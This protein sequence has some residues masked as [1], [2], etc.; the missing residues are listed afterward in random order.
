MITK[1]CRRARELFSPYFDEALS[2]DDNS[3]LE[4]HLSVCASCEKAYDRYRT[5][6]ESVRAMPPVEPSGMF[7]AK[8]RA[9]IRREGAAPRRSGWWHDFA[10]I[11]LPLP[12]GAA[13]LV[14]ISLFAYQ[15]MSGPGTST[16]VDSPRIAQTEPADSTPTRTNTRPSFLENFEPGG[17]GHV[18]STEPMGPPHPDAR[19]V[20]VR[21]DRDM[22]GHPLHGPYLTDR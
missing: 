13:A 21:T 1:Q 16:T 4:E 19:R 12:I 10:R 11:P 14:L 6:F 3:K 7:D 9:R 22:N 20:V 2:V 15:K 18:A 5:L 17:V 8:L